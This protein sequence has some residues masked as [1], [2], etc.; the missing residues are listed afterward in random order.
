[1][2][3]LPYTVEF[4]ARFS[5]ISRDL[6]DQ[7]FPRPL[8]GYFWYATL[9]ASGLESQFLFRYAVIRSGTQAV[10]IAP[11]FV[12]DVPISLVAPAPVAAV[13]RLLSRFSARIGFQKTLFAGSPCSDEGA[14]GLLP[15]H[16]LQQLAPVLVE[17]LEQEAR[18][19]GASMVVLKD[20]PE[21][22]LL[23]L[24]PA[25][26]KA[27]FFQITSYP[28]T[29]LPL[30]PPD[31][32]RHLAALPQTQRHNLRKKLRRSQE[33]LALET[34]VVDRP[35]DAE[36][37]EIFGL[38]EQTYQRGKTK[39][40]RLDRRFFEHIRECPEAKFIL[41][42]E[43]PGGRL[44]TFMLVFCLGDRVINKFIGLDYARAGKT[45]LYF[46]LFDAA[47]DLAYSSGAKELQSGQTGYR[48]KFDL[49]HQLVPLTNLVRHRNPLLNAV[50]RAIG[51]RVGWKSLDDD[52]AEYLK[53]H[54][55]AELAA[56]SVIK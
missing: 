32:T 13:I 46:R 11:C 36:L 9:E 31:K 7:C 15:G 37:G 18:R 20:F 54:P 49:G 21:K 17:A 44:L 35:G 24:A 29:L 28:G 33:I 53:A 22:P 1:M 43:K 45:Y 56:K 19:L 51:K 4:A 2:P 25:A 14:V 26:E 48:A 41:Q 12:H 8:E 10:G 52:L 3:S 30:P 39:F 38:F 55:E 23:A 50:F 47:L 40:E 5:D 16:D 27:G 42:R 6:W 34:S